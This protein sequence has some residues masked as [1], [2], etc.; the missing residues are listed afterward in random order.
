M[1]IR[2]NTAPSLRSKK[3]E[4]LIKNGYSKALVAAVKN[5]RERKDSTSGEFVEGIR[6][7]RIGRKKA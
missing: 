3:V 6:V 1:K 7:T 5:E 4:A 2:F